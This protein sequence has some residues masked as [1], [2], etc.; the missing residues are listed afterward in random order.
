MTSEQHR[1]QPTLCDV[2]LELVHFR[3]SALTDQRMIFPCMH[4]RTFA[5]VTVRNGAI[6]MWELRG[7]GLSNEELLTL[8][9]ME[10]AVAAH[11]GMKIQPDKS[12]S[13]KN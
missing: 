3:A 10:L 6:T 1:E 4:H 12:A 11:S 13:R 7:P 2:C 9:N 5:A 8:R